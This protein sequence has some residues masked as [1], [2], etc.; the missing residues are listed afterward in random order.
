M[1]IFQQIWHALTTPNKLL[2]DI[3]LIPLTFIE[4]TVTMLLFTTSLN[5]KSSKNQKILYVFILSILAIFSNTFIPRKYCILINIILSP[6]LVMLIFKTTILKGL[7]AQI[8]IFII[9][10]ILDTLILKTY[11]I[12]FNITYDDIL[13]IPIYRLIS[14][15]TIYL[16]YYL[17]FILS[18]RYNFNI[19]LLDDIHDKRSRNTLILNLILAII[20]ISTQFILAGFYSDKLPTFITILSMLSLLS[21]SFISIYSLT[22]TTKLEII[23]KNL[24]ESKL[25]NKTLSILY[26][27]I[28]GFKHDFSNIVQAIGRLR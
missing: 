16:T 25:Y 26:D 1:E 15:C 6:I 21:Y 24:E 12:T 3:L 8:F 11:L 7:T 10:S 27:N 19:N 13:I 22:K 18:K 2:I 9:S 14:I 23:S 17:L 4:M 5:I 20:S 28:R